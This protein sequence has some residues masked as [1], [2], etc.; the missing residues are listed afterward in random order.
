[1]QPEAEGG[2]RFGIVL[3]GSPLFT[4]G[5]GGGESEIRRHLLENDLVEAIVALPTDMFFNTGIATHVWI[6]SNRKPK[7]RLGKTQR[8]D[9]ST[10]FRKMRKSLGSKRREIGEKDR[11]RLAKLFGD[12]EPMDLVTLLYAD[13]REIGRK[14]LVPD[15]P[16]PDVPKGGR[17]KRAPV[18]LVLPNEAFG[19]HQI[20][21]ER[22]LVNERGEPVLVTRGKNKGE[23]QPDAALRKT[24][25]VPLSEEIEDYFA[26]E[27]LPHV[28]DAWID[29]SKIKVGYEI[30]FNR[31]FYVFEP[32][33]PLAEIDAGLGEVT[34]DIQAMLREMAA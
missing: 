20:T 30:P 18:S 27:V 14:I 31:H 3:N 11:G 33:R 1:M 13:G 24:E 32:P 28:P 29:E 2:C 26:R 17:A 12:G 22:P 23:P 4:G 34:A 8:I 15:A 16:T 21:V 10:F 6:V 9:G 5:A 25:T 19:Y 7:A